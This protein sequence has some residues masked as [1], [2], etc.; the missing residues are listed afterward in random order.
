M[1]QRSQS[2]RGMQ[3][4]PVAL[5]DD[6]SRYSGDI[7]SRSLPE[8]CTKDYGAAEGGGTTPKCILWIGIQGASSAKANSRRGSGSNFDF[9]SSSSGD[10]RPESD[11]GHFNASTPQLPQSLRSS[12]PTSA[13][14]GVAAC[15]AVQL[16]ASRLP[17]RWGW[18]S[19]RPHIRPPG[20]IPAARVARPQL[21][22]FQHEAAAARWL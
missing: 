11:G 7:S 16:R 6:R 10:P 3:N 22:I 4:S 5:F 19:Y 13:L 15:F 8:I 12:Q 20:S 18:G 1:R 17:R 9:S 14:L 2:L 21:Q